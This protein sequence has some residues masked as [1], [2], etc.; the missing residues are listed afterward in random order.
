MRQ[1]VWRQQRRCGAAAPSAAWRKLHLARRPPQALQRDLDR[2][3]RATAEATAARQAIQ[4]GASRCIAQGGGRPAHPHSRRRRAGCATR[5]D[6]VPA[7][8]S[9]AADGRPACGAG[10]ARGAGGSGRRYCGPPAEHGGPER[11]ADADAA[12]GAAAGASGASGRHHRAPSPS[13]E[14]AGQ[15]EQACQWQRHCTSG[16]DVAAD[17]ILRRP[18][19]VGGGA[20]RGALPQRAGQRTAVPV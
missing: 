8:L 4:G 11:H 16:S 10:Q 13:S 3:Q 5:A 20:E 17:G 6:G 7:G 15:A 18:T 14:E 2:A 1:P 12:D 9:A 19:A